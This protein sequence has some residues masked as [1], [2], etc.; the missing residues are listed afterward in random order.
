[1][2]ESVESSPSPESARPRT[3]ARLLS[4]ISSPPAKSTVDVLSEVLSEVVVEDDDDSSSRRESA[5]SETPKGKGDRADRIGSTGD[6]PPEK[7]PRVERAKLVRFVKEEDEDDGFEGLPADACGDEEAKSARIESLFDIG[8]KERRQGQGRFEKPRPPR[9][10]VR[11]DSSDGDFE[12]SHE[13]RFG[14]IDYD[15]VR[16]VE[17]E[18][19]DFLASWSS[20]AHTNDGQLRAFELLRRYIGE[21]GQTIVVPHGGIESSPS[22]P[23]GLAHF[24]TAG[25]GLSDEHFAK[26]VLTNS[27]QRRPISECWNLVYEA[28]GSDENWWT[29]NLRLW[30]IVPWEGHAR[31][32]GAIDAARGSPLFSDAMRAHD[33]FTPFVEKLVAVI[34]DGFMPCFIAT[35]GTAARE[36]VQRHLGLRHIATAAAPHMCWF[37]WRGIGKISSF[38]TSNFIACIGGLRGWDREAISNAH[39]KFV[40]NL[41]QK[42]LYFDDHDEYTPE[43]TAER[44][45]REKKERGEKK[46]RV[47]PTSVFG[48]T[49]GLEEEVHT[50]M[51]TETLDY[52][53]KFGWTVGTDRSARNRRRWSV[54]ERD[55]ELSHDD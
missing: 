25:I 50:M 45:A 48:W 23:L 20:V 30:N 37:T 33:N 1:M 9:S 28:S 24:K 19:S 40:A 6:S 29:N 5:S 44:A 2:A 8:S 36:F 54:V 46:K 31:A 43:T 55:G 38:D 26:V 22:R 35:F 15:G 49:F 11:A 12:F 18:I 13:Q 52:R 21:F 41:R 14:R 4:P 47:T 7:A 17:K 27:G 39:A 3:K 34:I 10:E 53:S 16:T 42:R 51:A 32:G